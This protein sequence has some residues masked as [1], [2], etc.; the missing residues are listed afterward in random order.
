MLFCCNTGKEEE[1]QELII[2]EQKQQKKLESCAEKVIAY[3]DAIKAVIKNAGFSFTVG[4]YF[5]SPAKIGN[6]VNGKFKGFIPLTCIEI[7]SLF[8]DTSVLLLRDIPQLR[9]KR[10]GD[11][12]GE[13]GSSH[14]LSCLW[15][16][17]KS[18]SDVFF[19]ACKRSLG[20]VGTSSAL[21]AMLWSVGTGEAVPPSN[22]GNA[23][24]FQFAGGLHIISEVIDIC[25]KFSAELKKCKSGDDETKMKKCWDKCWPKFCRTCSFN[26]KISDKL[27]DVFY[28]LFKNLFFGAEKV[29]SIGVTAGLITG[30]VYIIKAGLTNDK[31]LQKQ[32]LQTAGEIF[33][34]VAI[35]YAAAACKDFVKLGWKAACDLFTYCCKPVCK[36]IS[37]C[38]RFD[39]SRNPETDPNNFSL[40]I[41]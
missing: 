9:L 19:G 39:A 36:K 6:L 18:T 1:K 33:T 12:A 31:S 35:T 23:Q 38:C 27:K 4:E 30:L 7:A 25:N 34:G 37:D 32:N 20:I 8:W 2:N 28:Y 15:K 16:T 17:D 22:F 40:E 5:A 26:Q 21:F 41:F 24:A 29:L 13:Y 11:C 14:N 10:I 3:G